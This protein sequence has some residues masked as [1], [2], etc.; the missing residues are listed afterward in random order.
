MASNLITDNDKLPVQFKLVSS[1][2]VLLCCMTDELT[3]TNYL[4]VV[5]GLEEDRGEADGVGAGAG[6]SLPVSSLGE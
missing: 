6:T 5:D 3:M 4:S 1:D 2:Q